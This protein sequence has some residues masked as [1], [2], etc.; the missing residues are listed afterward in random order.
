MLAVTTFPVQHLERF[1][2]FLCNRKTRHR[3]KLKIIKV[4]FLFASARN[5]DVD[6]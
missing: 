1:V 4:Q 2:A 3:E 6:L 5:L